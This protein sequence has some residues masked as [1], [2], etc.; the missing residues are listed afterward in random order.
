MAKVTKRVFVLVKAYPQPSNTYEETVCCAG[1]TEAGE[2]I[3]LYPI[4]FRRLPASA[5]FDRFDLI[6]VQGE[7]P[8]DDH[9]PESFHVDEDSIRIVSR[10]AELSAE[11]KT[12]L[13]L[14][15]VA[16]SLG[17]LRQANADSRVSLGIVK[18]DAG[19]V[20]FS[21]VPHDKLD[22]ADADISRSL[23]KQTSLIESPLKPLAPP[24]YSFLYT[25]ESAGK[26]SRGQIHD[27]EVQAA[28]LNYRRKYGARAL[29]MLRRAYQ[30]DIPAK[31]LHLFL[32]TMKAHPTQF[33][34]VGVL[35]T[36]ADPDAIRAQHSLFS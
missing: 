35:R 19:S 5:H 11:S 22:K 17:A 3:R 20:R 14:P 30:V 23:V 4:R 8:R 10:S 1:I 24:E 6:E 18:P 16:A 28:Y 29:E 31:N 34:I 25:Y 2:F 9:R 26:R 13:W 15:H 21:W 7:R 36:S 27:W 12:A 32:G 33:I